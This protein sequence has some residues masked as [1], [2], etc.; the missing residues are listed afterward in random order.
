MWL[1]RLLGRDGTSQ[2]EVGPTHFAAAV[3]QRPLDYKT[4]GSYRVAVRTGTLAAALAAG[5]TIFS[6]RWGDATKM[7]VI[8]KVTARLLPLT[9]F[10]AATLTDH[11]SLDLITARSFTASDTGGTAI[12][13]TG[14]NQ[15]LRTTMASSAF[16]DMRISTTAALTAGTRTPDA[17][18][19]AASIRKGNRVNPAAATEET[20]Q[21]T[22]NILAYAPDVA[23][24][25][26]PITLVQNEGILIRNVTVWPAAG[27]AVVAIEIAWS[28]LPTASDY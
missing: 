26:H 19:M 17:Q 7:C 23:A 5:A 4:A 12:T 28:E 10:T 1:T 18:A 27:T 15:K 16:T 11:T 24:G 8:Q 6:A 25:E 14:N 3:Q 21:P 13:L 22:D 9:P 2:L 20:I